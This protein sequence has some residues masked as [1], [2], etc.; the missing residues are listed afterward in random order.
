MEGVYIFL[1][2]LLS[3]PYFCSHRE[4]YNSYGIHTCMN[5]QMITPH[6]MMILLKTY[7]LNN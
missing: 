4:C 5:D 1:Y 7:L 2:L 3:R 6:N